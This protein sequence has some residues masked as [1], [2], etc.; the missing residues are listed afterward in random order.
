MGFVL[1]KSKAGSAV[2]L[3]GLIPQESE[4]LMAAPILASE[5]PCSE[6]YNVACEKFD[7]HME[8]FYQEL[9][10]LN[11]P[12]HVFAD[13]YDAAGRVIADA[14]QGAFAVGYNMGLSVDVFARVERSVIGWN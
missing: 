7:D 1:P 12:E 11:L 14:E 6:L 13:V 8:A 3:T 4:L 9:R 5:L 2:T 10:K